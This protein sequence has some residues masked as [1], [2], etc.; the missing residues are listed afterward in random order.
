MN[1]AYKK[2][3]ESACRKIEEGDYSASNKKLISDFFDYLRM[4]EI[5]WGARSHYAAFLKRFIDFTNGKSLRK[6]T[7]KDFVDFLDYRRECVKPY[8]VHLTYAK[9]RRF[10][11]WLNKGKLPYEFEQVQVHKPNHSR[12]NAEEILSKSDVMALV[13][14]V[15]NTRD[16]ALIYCLWESGCRISEFLGVKLSELKIDD[17]IVSFKVNG[18]TGERNCYLIE[19]IPAIMDWLN[20][21]PKK[22]DPD[23]PLWINWEITRGRHLRRDQAF[24]IIKRAACAAGI[25][26]PVFLHALRHSRATF[27]ARQGKNESFLRIYFGWSSKS[28]QPTNYVKLVQSDIKDELLVSSGYVKR[29]PEESMDNPRQCPRCKTLNDIEA[30]YCKKCYLVIDPQKAMELE[31]KNGKALNMMQSLI[32]N[33][34][35]LEQKGFDLQQFN[36]FMESWVKANGKD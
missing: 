4:Q 3:F 21:H 6:C 7:A 25:K 27:M 8:T 36:K 15:S 20:V 26:K 33:F 30:Q 12:V 9:L 22:K 34:N 28:N 32:N 13:N 16:K 29:K 35:E 17:K 18:K 24:R 14:A 1:P 5:D 31:D 10:F 2:V 23:A 11:E 19:S